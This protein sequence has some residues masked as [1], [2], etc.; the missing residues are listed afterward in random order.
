[1][2]IFADITLPIKALPFERTAGAKT[3]PDGTTRRFNSTKYTGYKEKLSWMMKSHRPI[4]PFLGPIKVRVDTLH[5]IPESWTQAKREQSRHG[6][7]PSTP[8]VDNYVK[9]V[10]D[11]MQGGWFK[12]DSQVGIVDGRKFWGDQ[13]GMRIMVWHQLDP[14]FP[15][16]EAIQLEINLNKLRQG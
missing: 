14:K 7:K 10:L 15:Y 8:D 13:D 4:E 2:I 6:I 9:A 3:M 11:S 16:P 1:M 12:N 5:Q